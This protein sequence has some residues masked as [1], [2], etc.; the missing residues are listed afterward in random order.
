M[1][2]LTAIAAAAAMLSSPALAGDNKGYV[3]LESGSTWTQGQVLGGKVGL[4]PMK[5][6]GV[7][8]GYTHVFNTLAPSEIWTGDVVLSVPVDGVKVVPFALADEIQRRAHTEGV[9]VL[10][11]L[12]VAGGSVLR[13]R[14]TVRTAVTVSRPIVVTRSYP[15]YVGSSYGRF[16]PQTRGVSGGSS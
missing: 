10:L 16:S 7:E 4:Q 15:V 5:F 12:D 3:E 14:S 1:K 13:A 8:T 2:K 11:C 6:I 9:R